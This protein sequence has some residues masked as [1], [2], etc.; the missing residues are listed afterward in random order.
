MPSDEFTC[1]RC[2]RK[3]IQPVEQWDVD[4]LAVHYIERVEK[5]YP[6]SRTLEYCDAVKSVIL[7][8]SAVSVAP[9]VRKVEK[10]KVKREELF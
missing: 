9:V 8:R 4:F 1:P 6:M 3:T 10:L 7:P 5:P 2:G